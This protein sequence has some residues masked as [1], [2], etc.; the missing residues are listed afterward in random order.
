LSAIPAG[1]KVISASLELTTNSITGTVT[2]FG[3][4]F[5]PI[6]G[7]WAEGAVTF[8][9]QPAYGPLS[10]YG[11]L[12]S[13][14]EGRATFDV[15]D[16]VTGW[17]SGTVTNNGMMLEKA[18]AE[19]VEGTL[20][21]RSSDHITATD[22]PKLTVVFEGNLLTQPNFGVAMDIFPAIGAP[23]EFASTNAAVVANRPAI[24]V[25]GQNF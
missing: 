17:V 15:T 18:V 21:V 6:L 22:R 23:V 4:N 25:V 12:N 20:S 24:V 7:T 13:V 8:N 19:S 10:T 14:A 1:S 2:D 11:L 5:F 3:L 9:T 16:L